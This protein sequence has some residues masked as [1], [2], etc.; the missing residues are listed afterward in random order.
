MNRLN[1]TLRGAIQGKVYQAL[2][3][4]ADV[5]DNRAKTVY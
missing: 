4:A 1:S 2:E 3:N 5:E